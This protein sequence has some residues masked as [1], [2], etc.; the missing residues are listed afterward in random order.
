MAEGG[1]NSEHRFFPSIGMKYSIIVNLQ[2]QRSLGLRRRIHVQT[3]TS[4]P[5]VAKS[6]PRFHF[7]MNASLNIPSQTP[8]AVEI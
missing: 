5:V 3:N 4:V 6:S 8:D 2:A 7:S 1:E